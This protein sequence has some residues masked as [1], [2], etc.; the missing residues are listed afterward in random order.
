M[1]TQTS[2]MCVECCVLVI[3]FSFKKEVPRKE[4]YIKY[5]AKTPQLKSGEIQKISDFPRWHSKSLNFPDL[6]AIVDTVFTGWG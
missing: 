3:Y 6:V 1:N 4:K 2:Y 5:I